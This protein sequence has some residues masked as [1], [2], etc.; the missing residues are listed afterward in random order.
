MNQSITK[1]AE[2]TSDVDVFKEVQSLIANRNRRCRA[3][4]LK[5]DGTIREMTFVP[6]NSWLKTMGL[7]AP[8]EQGKKMVNTK[9][10]RGMVTVVEV[11]TGDLGCQHCV[12]PRTINLATLV[13][14]LA[15]L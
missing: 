14:P 11:F 8:T 13:E 15:F 1:V 9:C 3:K 4:F 12:R 10:H 7:G 6:H 5:Q 2:L